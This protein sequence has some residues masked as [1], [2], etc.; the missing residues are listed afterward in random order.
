MNT[1]AQLTA[2]IR[3]GAYDRVFAHLYG[4]ESVPRQRQRY[5]EA[6]AAF[7]AV[8]GKEED[9][10]LFSAPGRT[11]IG[12]NHTDHNHGCV[13]A[14]SVNLD[15]IAVASRSAEN[16]IRIQSKGY[17]MDVIDCCELSVQQK[18]S[19]IPPRSFAGQPPNFGRTATLSEASTLIPPPMY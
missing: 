16:R 4:E 9:L 12:G 19:T 15:V 18:R 13:L 14:A 7:V 3:S 2:S 11:E 1:A 8:F 10:H 6:I 17:P 5:I